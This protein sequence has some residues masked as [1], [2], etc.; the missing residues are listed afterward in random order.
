MA[1][2]SSVFDTLQQSIV[3]Q[4]VVAICA[5]L[6]VSYNALFLRRRKGWR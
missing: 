3:L 5:A 6:V 2:L 1:I 4:I